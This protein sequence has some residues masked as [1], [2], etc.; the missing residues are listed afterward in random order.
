LE[1]VVRGVGIKLADPAAI[2]RL[3]YRGDDQLVARVAEPPVA[4]LQHLGEVVPGVDVKHRKWE[5]HWRKRLLGQTQEHDR[6]LAAAEQE[7]RA[8]ELGDHLAQNVDRL[9]LEE[10]E[11]VEP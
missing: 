9:G 1:L 6:V 5:R 7:D 10:T 2:D 4:E 3:L 8:F 11:V